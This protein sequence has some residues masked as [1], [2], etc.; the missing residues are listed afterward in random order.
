M[1]QVNPPPTLRT[2]REL[3]QNRNT[4]R[5]FRDIE[6]ILLQLWTRTG[7]EEDLIES[8]EQ[9]QTATS[10]RVSRNAAK[11]NA[12]EL[13]EFEVINTTSNLTTEPNQIIICRNTTPITITLDSQA[14]IEDE[15]HIKRRDATI[16]VVGSIDGFAN[17]TINVKNYSMHLVFDG[18]DWSEI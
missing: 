14:V 3:S 7:G 4:E 15:V 6:T 10:S 9:T 8:G 1:A 16:S 11:I 18:T 5:Y 17:R 12:L 13:K 2:P